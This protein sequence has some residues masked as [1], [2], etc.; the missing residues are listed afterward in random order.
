MMATIP[1]GSYT[2]G[3]DIAPGTYIVS[4][5][6]GKGSV[7]FRRLSGLDREGRPLSEPRDV[8]KRYDPD[9]KSGEPLVP[10]RFEAIEGSTLSVEP[11]LIVQIARASMIVI[12]DEEPLRA[13]SI[14]DVSPDSERF[15]WRSGNQ[16]ADQ[17]LES[18]D[19]LSDEDALSGARSAESAPEGVIHQDDGEAASVAGES[20]QKLGPSRSACNDS[21]AAERQKLVSWERRLL[22]LSMRNRLLNLNLGARSGYLSLSEPDSKTIWSN[23]VEN[24]EKVVLPLRTRRDYFDE[25]AE[26]EEYRR[27]V[28]QHALEG[29]SL[30]STMPREYDLGSNEAISDYPASEMRKRLKN[31]R[32]WLVC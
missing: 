28:E 9:P 14:S 4:Y 11:G 2:F 23:F 17:S 8:S 5:A 32:S 1:A 18:P 21:V 31:I 6:S 10:I 16:L 15:E 22:D 20:L 19:G 13:H 29:R 12:D 30:R 27:L 24:S 25:L 3:V 7:E 26:Y